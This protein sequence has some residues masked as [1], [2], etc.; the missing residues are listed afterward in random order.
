[1][2]SKTRS[3]LT[4]FG[5]VIGITAIVALGSVSEGLRI[6]ISE[7]L[8]MAAGL[9]YVYEESDQPL[10]LA[11]ASSSLSEEKIQEIEDVGGI[12]ESAR[13]VMDIAYL[14]GDQQF[15][16]PDLFINGVDP[17]NEELLVTESAELDDGETL[18][19][20]DAYSAT[21]GYSLAQDLDIGVGDTIELKEENF[22]IVGVYKKIG[23]PGLDNGV[24][25]P[26]ETALDLLDTEEYSG[27]IVYPEDLDDVEE[28]TDYINE[29][30]EG[31][32]ALSTEDVAI[33]ISSVI[34]QIQ[35]FTFGIAGISAIVGGLGVLNTMIMSIMERKREIG[36]MKAVGATNNCILQQ[37]LTES[38]IIT[39]FGGLAGVILGS[40]GAYSL[41]FISSALE[42]A[43]VTPSL[44][45][46]SLIFAVLL[47]LLGGFYPAWK[48]SKLDPIE[49]I[50]Y[51]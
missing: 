9:I 29:N 11:M 27:I 25:I 45:I 22:V 51:E 26:I 5:I 24:L 39:F 35:I 20:G 17:E 3:F 50:R 32:T 44:A 14:D 18:E 48:A 42:S 1:M 37:I 12:K 10:F 8:E 46:G 2:R 34:D 7:A 6:Q 4:T 47:G 16:Q 21:I 13:F 31:V 33:T 19:G 30:I 28:I 38:V 23:D 36:I 41:R 15:G 43:T 49:A 40:L